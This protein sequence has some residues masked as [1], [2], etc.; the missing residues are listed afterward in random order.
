[1]NVV[2]ST[3]FFSLSIAVLVWVIYGI[4]SK[5]QDKNLKIGKSV[6][7]AWYFLTAGDAMRSTDDFS[8]GFIML[9]VGS[10]TAFYLSK[11]KPK[12]EGVNN[13]D[14]DKVKKEIAALRKFGSSSKP[15]SASGFNNNQSSEHDGMHETQCI[16][17]SYVDSIGNHTRREVDV[18]SVDDEYIYGY[19]HLVG[20][21]RTFLLNR[22]EGNIIVID[23]G[24]LLDPYEWASSFN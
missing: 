23:T 7:A 1:M 10:A 19:C 9:I 5:P 2:I 20:D 24:E 21:T 12:S 22:I 11:R 3:A 8:V 6:L 14:E 15:V 16:S 4:C 17:F 13:N 18:E